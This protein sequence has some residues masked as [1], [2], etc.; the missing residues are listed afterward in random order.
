M[1]MNVPTVVVTVGMCADNSL[2]PCEMVAAKLLAESLGA[3]NRQPILNSIA[4]VKADY[5]VMGFNV[6][7]GAILAILKIRLHTGDSE[8]I[9]SAVQGRK[10][11]VISRNQPTT[12]IENRLVC[13]LVVFKQ[14]IFLGGSVVGI[15]RA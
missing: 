11:T 6:A 7:A 12:F 1:T 3:V 9:F 13:E 2:M 4:R 14:Q 10:A 15:F 5:V 8:I